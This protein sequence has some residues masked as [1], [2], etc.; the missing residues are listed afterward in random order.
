MRID[1]SLNE[2]QIVGREQDY[3]KGIRDGLGAKAASMIIGERS[4]ETTTPTIDSHV[5][6]LKSVGNRCSFSTALAHL[7]ALS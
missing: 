5:V 6:E 3:V 7:P 1:A 4:Y 2:G